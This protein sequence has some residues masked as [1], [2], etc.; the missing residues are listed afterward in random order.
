MVATSMVRAA[1]HAVGAHSELVVKHL[2]PVGTV[3]RILPNGSALVLCRTVMTGFRIRSTGAGGQCMNRRWPRCGS[4]LRPVRASCSTSAL[5]SAFMH[6][7]LLTRSPRAGSL[8][9]GPPYCV[10]K[11]DPK[12]GLERRGERAMHAGCM[13]GTGR[14]GRAVRSGWSGYS[15]RVHTGVRVHEARVGDPLLSG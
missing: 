14:H 7:W 11:V 8:R 13:W 9:W 2:R 4:T 1:L 12:R 15:V 3:R 5:T 6:S 10:R